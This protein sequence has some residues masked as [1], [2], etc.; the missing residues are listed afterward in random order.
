MTQNQIVGI[1]VMP[2][3][4]QSETINGVL[5]N[6][7]NKA[8]VTAVSISPYVMGEIDKDKGSREPPIDAGAGTVRLLDRSLWGKR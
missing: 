3:Y 5:D 2:E 7:Q 6:L 8:R 4:I 1:T